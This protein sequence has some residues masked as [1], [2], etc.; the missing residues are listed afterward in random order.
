MTKL[1]ATR[2]AICN[3]EVN[4]GPLA[5]ETSSSV[6]G[7]PSLAIVAVTIAVANAILVTL[8]ELRARF[9]KAD[10][11]PSLLSSTTLRTELLLGALNNAIPEL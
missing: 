7:N 2:N 6:A 8:A 9:K 10:T 3:P 5:P 11:T 1:P 4:A